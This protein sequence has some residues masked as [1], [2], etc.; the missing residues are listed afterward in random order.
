LDITG[1]IW[2]HASYLLVEFSREVFDL[3]AIHLPDGFWTKYLGTIG[4][5]SFVDERDKD[6]EVVRRSAEST[7]TARVKLGA[8]SVHKVFY[9]FS[10]TMRVSN[11]QQ[12][13][14]RHWEGKTPHTTRLELAF[15][16]L[17]VQPDKSRL[18]VGQEFK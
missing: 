13:T 16:R 2:H 3:V 1:Q 14:R 4:S 9:R 5:L 17:L 15:R 11:A 6:L 8:L 7:R 10:D 12:D 18:S